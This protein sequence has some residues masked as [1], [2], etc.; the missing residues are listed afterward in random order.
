MS[1]QGGIIRAVESYARATGSALSPHWAAELGD[2]PLADGVNALASLTGVL[3]WP[4]PRRIEGRPRPDQFPLL[5]HDPASN[6]A[7]V[8]VGQR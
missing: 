8:P 2:G 6:W 5:V 7:V 3:G 1:E 4:P